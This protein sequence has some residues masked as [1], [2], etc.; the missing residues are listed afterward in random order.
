MW[1]CSEI[2]LHIEVHSGWS[3]KGRIISQI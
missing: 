1:L 3:Y 2:K